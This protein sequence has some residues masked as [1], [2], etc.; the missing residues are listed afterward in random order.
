[1][2]IAKE[3]YEE[4]KKFLAFI[5]KR[6]FGQRRDDTDLWPSEILTQTEQRSTALARKG[7]SSALNDLLSYTAGLTPSQ[8]KS[9]DEEL[10]AKSAWTLSQMR[11]KYWSRYK[12]IIKINKIQNDDE[13]YLI[14]SILED[15]NEGSGI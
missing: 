2:M 11:A 15:T 9:L 1:M 7:L 12:R 10:S 4:A 6:I 3:D 8:I 13:Y 5:E 14:K